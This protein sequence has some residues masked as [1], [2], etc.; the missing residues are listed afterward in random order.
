MLKK[1]ITYLDYDGETVTDTFYF[2]MSEAE[3]IMM[4][5]T[6]IGGLENLLEKIISERD[7]GKLASLI[8]EIILKS[9]GKRNADSRRFEKSE[10]ISR[11][12]EQTQAY[13][14]LFVELVTDASKC[15][16][17]V[18]AIIPSEMQKELAKHPEFNVIPTA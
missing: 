6:P 4:N 10:E 18:N 8:R 12:F 16:E 17:F 9:Y 7:A 14:K 1:T 13:S 11:E 15:A 3:I 5:A 2:H